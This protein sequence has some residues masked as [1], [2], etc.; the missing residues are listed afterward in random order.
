METGGPV[1]SAKQSAPQWIWVRVG[2]DVVPLKAVFT[3]CYALDSYAL[4]CYALDRLD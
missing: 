1:P 4:D 3:D 2:S